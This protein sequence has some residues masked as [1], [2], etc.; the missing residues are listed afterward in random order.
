[1]ELDHAVGLEVDALGVVGGEQSEGLVEAVCVP[2]KGEGEMG[3]VVD[4]DL[5]LVGVST[6]LARAVAS[7]APCMCRST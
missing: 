4:V 2:R 3:Q 7:C 6:G 1:M 5:G